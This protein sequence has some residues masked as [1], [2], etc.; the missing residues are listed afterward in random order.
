MLKH[1]F[2]AA[3]TALFLAA[4]LAGA[5]A[6]K[7]LRH[8][9]GN[10][11]R[12][13]ETPEWRL[14]INAPQPG[15]ALLKVKVTDGNGRT[16]AEVE[17]KIP[18]IKGKTPVEFQLPALDH[19]YYEA[20]YTLELP[21]GKKSEVKSTF[22][23]AP[24]FNRS[25]KE[26]RDNGYC[27]G[28]K[29][30]RLRDGWNTPEAVEACRRLGLQWTREI[31]QERNHPD[32]VELCTDFQ[33][34]PVFKVERFPEKL[35]DAEKYG[36][37]E[38]WV[39]K[40]GKTWMLRTLPKKEAYQ[41]WLQ[42][43][44]SRIPEDRQVFEIWNEAWDKMS[45]EDFATIS[46][47]IAEAILEIRP[48]AIIGPNLTGMPGKYTYD[49]N[50]IRAGGMKHMKMIALH[51][52]GNAERRGYIETYRKWIREQLGHDVEIYITEF[53]T[54]S[55]PEGPSAQSE[56]EQ[57]RK[58]V[59]Q[60]LN[61][62]SEN[63]RALTPHWMGQR[64]S[65]RRYHEHWF[66]FFRRNNELKPVL[67]AYATAARMVDGSRY[68][69]ELW[70][71]PG[72]DAMLFEKD[73]VYTL[74]LFT[75]GK[76]QELTIEPGTKQLTLIDFWGKEQTV[77][78]P[79]DG[80]LKLTVDGDVR[81]LRGVSP[82]MARAAKLTPNPDRWPEDK[83]EVFVRN[84]RILKPVTRTPSFTGNM[85]EWENLTELAMTN[86]RV[87]GDDAS[88]FAYL[89]YDR[90]Y[91][92][93]GLD[94]R[95]NEVMN[96]QPDNRLYSDDSME[97]FISS[98]PRDDEPGYGPDDRQFFATPTSRSGKPV[99]CRV[100]NRQNGTIVPVP[101]AKYQVQVH[102]RGWKAEVALPWKELSDFDAKPGAV[103]ALELRVND[104][105]KSHPR[106]KIDPTDIR[107]LSTED[108]TKWS[109]LKLQ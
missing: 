9:P 73:G 36:P 101:G 2:A 3:A 107:N 71:E 100:A 58:V 51:P 29:M 28:V 8:A 78:V 88:G 87:N 60:A 26:A 10:L 42:E 31:L 1:T 37:L 33:M 53:G 40:Y 59:R 96:R 105:D 99:L 64:E 23:I 27:F 106:W 81:Y 66:G 18:V 4:P 25:A 49:A 70:Y 91:L 21:E 82:D 38:E 65:N 67:I 77:Q 92:Y 5:P 95:D 47:W 34:N 48:D 24:Q 86:P 69:G 12:P 72:S 61:L 55:T 63:V 52:Y 30:Y 50:Y 35:Y 102:A 13:G 54:H 39:K 103:L 11:F 109:L 43:E 20:A 83:T 68:V 90:E 6:L 85:K 17:K 74:A 44:I 56:R 97:I 14:E 32:T 41:K 16:V 45:A 79:A 15:E 22:G 93:I 57:A 46:Q 89:G 94:M 98:V 104:A 7:V 84:S 75:R 108:P 76:P 80:K 19:G 62:Y